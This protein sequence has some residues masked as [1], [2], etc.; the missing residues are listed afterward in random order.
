MKSF[1]TAIRNGQTGFAVRNSVFL[2]FHC[3]IISIW[4]GKEMS[5]L[6]V[7]DQIT[8]LGDAEQI[9]VREGE[10]YTNLVFRKWG[11]LAKEL[12]NHKGHI[13]LHATEKGEDIFREENRC[14]IKIGFHDHRKELS[15]DIVNNPFEL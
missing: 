13:I 5:L 9:S 14:Y 3:E 11:D 2:P 8:D 1:V 10:S 12:G 15:F 7:P 4:I 6:S